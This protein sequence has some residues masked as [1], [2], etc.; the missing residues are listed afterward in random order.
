MINIY[1]NHGLKSD[2]SGEEVVNFNDDTIQKI[3]NNLQVYCK[4]N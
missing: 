2:R 1:G 3:K 4:Y